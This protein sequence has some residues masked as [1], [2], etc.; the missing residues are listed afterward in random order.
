MQPELFED[1][2]GVA[3]SRSAQRPLFPYRFLR[4]RVAYEDI[5]FAALG[6]LLVLLAG[7]CLGVE[8]GKLVTALHTTPVPVVSS[9]GAELPTKELK[10]LQPVATKEPSSTGRYAIQVASFLD[11]AP[12]EREAQRLR[13]QGLAPQVIAQGRFFELRVVGF[14]SREEALGPLASLRK[15]YRDSFVKRVSSGQ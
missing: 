6:I 11:R 1:L 13:H 8:R 9:V 5:V 7:F 12:A 3:R 10:T 14:R 4:V 15:M 2:D